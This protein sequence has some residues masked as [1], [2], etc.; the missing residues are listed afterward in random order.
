[1]APGYF[2]YWQPQP[3]YKLKNHGV[4]ESDKQFSLYTTRFWNL[5]LNSY[6]LILHCDVTA[7]LKAKQQNDKKEQHKTENEKKMGA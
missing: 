1:M 2:N 6:R 7:T 5:V 3:D 4:Y